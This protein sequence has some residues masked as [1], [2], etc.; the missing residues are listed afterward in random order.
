MH[1]DRITMTYPTLNN[2]PPTSFSPRGSEKAEVLKPVLEGSEGE[3]FPSQKISRW[4][5]A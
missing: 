1:S 3:S 5:D 4:M 2:R